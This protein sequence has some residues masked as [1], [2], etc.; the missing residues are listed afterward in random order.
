MFFFF[1]EIVTINILFSRF[2]SGFHFAFYFSNI[3][4]PSFLLSLPFLTLPLSLSPSSFLPT[5]CVFVCLKLI[6]ICSNVSSKL[7]SSSYLTH[8]FSFKN[9]FCKSHHLILICGFEHR[10][11]EASS[12]S[13]LL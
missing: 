1:F 9:D 4:S 8:K 6:D 3:C 13:S 11:H 5:L 12:G 7:S 10:L 2:T